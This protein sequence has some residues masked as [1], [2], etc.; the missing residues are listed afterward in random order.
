[1][2]SRNAPEITKGDILLFETE[3]Q[4]HNQ[5]QLKDFI[6]FLK[7]C[8]KRGAI[9]FNHVEEKATLL[10]NLTLKENILLDSGMKRNEDKSLVKLLA[11][12]GLTYLSLLA[13]KLDDE[14]LYPNQVDIEAKKITSLIKVLFSSADYLFLERP[15]KYL[16]KSTQDLFISALFQSLTQ[17]GQILLLTSDQRN[18]WLQHVT[19]VVTRSKNSHFSLDA[20]ISQSEVINKGHLEFE[21]PLFSHKKAA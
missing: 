13:K 19:K 7:Y 17:K 4:K 11:E 21:G 12:K 1:M 15:E 14:N 9:K 8:G 16:S 6:Y 3:N 10:K 20:V 18:M 5:S 2:I